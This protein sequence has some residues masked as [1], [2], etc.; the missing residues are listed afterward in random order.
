MVSAI[1]HCD[2]SKAQVHNSQHK[3][4]LHHSTYRC[5]FHR[6]SVKST[7]YQLRNLPWMEVIHWK[8][9]HRLSRSICTDRSCKLSFDK[10]NVDLY[11]SIRLRFQF[12]MYLNGVWSVFKSD[13]C[14]FWI[15]LSISLK[16]L[17]EYY[18]KD[19]KILLNV[20]EKYLCQFHTIST[21]LI[22]SFNN[23][24]LKMEKLVIVAITR[25]NKFKF[26]QV[27]DFQESE[28]FD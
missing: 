3:K 5:E 6:R 22:F 8:S 15:T 2:T 25:K 27:V 19:K 14:T 10:F 21:L 1:Y 11:R 23:K 20:K 13:T 28:R 18:W 9:R 17:Q 12:K 24:T 7:M 4:T 26:F 16:W